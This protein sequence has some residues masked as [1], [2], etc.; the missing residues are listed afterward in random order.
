MTLDDIFDEGG[1]LAQAMQGY[2]ARQQQKDM[3]LAVQRTIRNKEILIA[4]A[5][6]G[7][8][9]TF[10]Y[11][12][13]VLLEGGKAIISTGT[14]TLQD[15]LFNRDIQHIRTLLGRPVTVALLKGRANYVCHYYLDRASTQG[16]FT[17]REDINDL[18]QIQRYAR[19]TQSGDKA[20]LPTVSEEAPVWHQVTSSRDNCLGQECPFHQDCFVLKARKAAQEADIVVV[21]H[22]L[23][24]AD[25]WLKDEGSGELLPKCN[26]VIFDEA[27]QLP[28]VASTFFGNNLTSGQLLELA[29]DSKIESLTQAKDFAALPLAIDG[30]E[31]AVRD[32]RLVFK[33]EQIRLPCHLLQDNK[34]FHAALAELSDALA[35]V[36]LLLKAQEERSEGF[37]NLTRRAAELLGVLEGWGKLQEDYIHWLDISTHHFVLNA[38]PLNIAELFHK[39]I[40]GQNR[41]WIFV[42]ATLAV[43]G[44]FTHYQHELGLQEAHTALWDSPFDYKAQAVLYVP[45][46]MPLVNTPEFTHAVIKEALPLLQMTKGHAFL[47]FTSLKA[48]REGYELL[49][50]EL[51]QLGLSYPVFMQGQASRTQLLEKFRAQKHAILVASQTFWEGVDVKGE[52]LSLVVIDKLPFS[53]PDDPILSAR[54]E[55]IERAGGNAFVEYQLPRAVLSLK[56]GAGRLIRDESDRGILMVADTRLVEKK[57][58]KQ[59]WRSLPAMRRTRERTV[60]QQFWD[61]VNLRQ[62]EQENVV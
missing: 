3:A 19:S 14:K 13:P 28:E 1:V 53:P 45:K 21:N 47:L 25:V 54:I 55:R 46:T 50:K 8:G 31:K 57:Y 26:T 4:E 11:L 16:R 40:G 51:D 38:T 6:T 48:M 17:R 7:T 2:R 35:Q 9:K 15:Q 62:S 5:G 24:F 10:A 36:A 52:Q 23:F 27:H 59:I 58:G 56:Q 37:K 61:Q 39:Q 41:A 60:V 29:R 43:D 34:A 44:V 33:A 22:H 20:A 18:V 12:I 30:L 32:M 49:C 42:S